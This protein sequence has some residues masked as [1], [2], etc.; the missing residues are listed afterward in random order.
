M[1][2]A[3]L[4]SWKSLFFVAV[5]AASAAAR[6]NVVDIPAAQDATL[7][8]GADAAANKSL[9][10]PGI[11]VGTDGQDNPK[12]GLIEFDIASALPAGAAISSA[13]MQL[14]LG[15]V[16][17]SGG[18][19]GSGS[20]QTVS[21]YDETQA[22][23][24]PTNIAG[25][26]SFAGAGHGDN[27]AT[28]DATWNDAFYSSTSWTAAGGDYVSGASDRGDASVGTSLTTYSWS[29]SAMVA[30]VQ[31]WLDNPSSNFGWL[32]KN[33][34]ETDSADFRAFWSAQGAANYLAANPSN[35][36]GV[37]APVL[38]VTYVVPEPGCLA[39]LAA[40][41]LLPLMRR[42]LPHRL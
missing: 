28:G 23:G 33:A 5:I 18:G 38:I 7:L 9:S 34:D 26:T 27:P 12:R 37:A 11:F 31:N 32:L 3:M 42:R 15:Q 41:G 2:M 22:W 35:P 13:T 21:L 30:D 17:G 39:L 8:G 19:S 20:S 16:G 14:V 1:S 36:L 24:Q 40:G 25:A 6:A 4:K 29:S 10:D